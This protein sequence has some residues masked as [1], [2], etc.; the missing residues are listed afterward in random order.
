MFIELCKLLFLTAR[1]W[2]RRLGAAA[3]RESA[4]AFRLPVRAWWLPAL[5][6]DAR[7]ARRV[8]ALAQRL[9]RMGAKIESL[10]AHVR[11]ASYPDAVD[12]DTSF[13]VMLTELKQ[14]MRA[15][16]CEVAGWQCDSAAAGSM[17]LQLALATIAAISERIFTLADQLLWD[18]AERDRVRGVPA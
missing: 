8:E 4:L 2:L 15:L 18:L 12:G 14:D 10:R 5:F 7:C 3:R 11:C 9:M 16:R 1:E 17:R 6:A 13:R